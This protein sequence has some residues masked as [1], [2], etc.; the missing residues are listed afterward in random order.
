MKTIITASH[1]SSFDLDVALMLYYCLNELPAPCFAASRMKLPCSAFQIQLIEHVLAA[2]IARTLSPLGW[3]KSKRDM[4]SQMN[5]LYLVHPWLDT[6]G[7]R[8]YAKW[9]I[10]GRRCATTLTGHGR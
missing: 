3:W 1:S 9:R 6:P 8:G 10:P 7:V 4:T 5:A 2:F